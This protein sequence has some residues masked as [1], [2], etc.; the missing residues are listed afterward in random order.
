GVPPDLRLLGGGHVHDHAALEHLG[1]PRLDPERAGLLVHRDL[2]EPGP[3]ARTRWRSVYSGL[4]AVDLA[5]PSRIM[6]IF[7][8]IQPTGRK[9]LGNYLAAINHYVAGQD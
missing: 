3:A 8:G 1:Q 7:S 4:H 2:L 9:Q 5:I 6:R